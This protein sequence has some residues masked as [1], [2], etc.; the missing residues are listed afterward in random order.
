MLLVALS[1]CSYTFNKISVQ[2]LLDRLA[3]VQ[4][5]HMQ[6]AGFASCDLWE[7]CDAMRCMQGNAMQ[8]PYAESQQ[9]LLQVQVLA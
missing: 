4:T 1:T 6:L 2:S 9:E 5:G 7:V 3:L 8:V